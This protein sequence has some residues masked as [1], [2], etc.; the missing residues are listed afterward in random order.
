MTAF[1]LAHL[2]SAQPHPEVFEYMERIQATLDPFGGRFRIH[3]AAPEVK[4]GTWQ[5]TPVLIEFPTM[6]AARAWYDSPAY[7]HILP[8][9]T[10]HLEG[11]L[12]LIE[13]VGPD[14][15]SARLAGEL[16]A[17]TSQ[18]PSAAPSS[19]ARP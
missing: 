3:G 14:H 10:R 11:E 6:A 5:G 17:L 18:V 12:L 8:L 19:V 15:D 2:R 7:R 9:R 13:G 16:R 4:E 1:A